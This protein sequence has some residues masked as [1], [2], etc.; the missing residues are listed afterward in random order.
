MARKKERMPTYLSAQALI[1][2]GY[3][4][5]Q[6]L[7]QYKENRQRIQAMNLRERGKELTSEETYRRKQAMYES[8][9][10]NIGK[11][12]LITEGA[13]SYARRASGFLARNLPA[14]HR[15]AGGRGGFARALYRGQGQLPP[16]NVQNRFKTIQGIKSGKRGRPI[17]TIDKRYQ[18]FGGVYGYRKYVTHQRFLERQAALQSRAVTPQQQAILQQIRAREQ[19]ARSNPEGRVIPSTNGDVFLDGIMDEINRAAMAV[20]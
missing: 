14:A 18:S 9:K 5:P 4:S 16:T 19:Y 15:V 2:K 8:G 17:G 12:G 11:G 20:G 7:E 13:R 6:E 1:A 10:G 3:Y